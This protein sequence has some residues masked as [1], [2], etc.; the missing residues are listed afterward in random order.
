MALDGSAYVGLARVWRPL[1]GDDLPRLGCVGVRRGYR[2]RGLARALIAAAFVSLVERG[3]RAVTT[4]VDETNVASNALFASLGA[5]RT[6]SSIEL[7]RPAK[8]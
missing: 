1:P 8:S 3:V 2:R 5:I 7:R 4:E 6:G